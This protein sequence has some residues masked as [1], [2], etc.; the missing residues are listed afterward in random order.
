MNCFQG[1]RR[2]SFDLGEKPAAVYENEVNSYTKRRYTTGTDDDSTP[3]TRE[4]DFLK[5]QIGL[6]NIDLMEA[7]NED[8]SLSLP[9]TN[10]S[11][12]HSDSPLNQSS[13]QPETIFVMEGIDSTKNSPLKR[14]AKV[15][16]KEEAAKLVMPKSEESAGTGETKSMKKRRRKKSVIKKKHAQKKAMPISEHAE[17]AETIQESADRSTSDS[18]ERSSLDSSQSEP[19][20]KEIQ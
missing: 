13:S 1:R 12:S 14:E 3:K 18:V 11:L 7:S 10:I 6:G 19:E 4:A 9:C 2:N 15:I 8:L 16:V 20:L 5:R 17:V